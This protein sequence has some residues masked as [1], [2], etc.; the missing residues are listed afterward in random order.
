[1]ET[2]GESAIAR[3]IGTV[4][5][6]LRQFRSGFPDL[7]VIHPNGEFEF[8]EVKAPGDQIQRNQRIW[9]EELAST[10]LPARVMRFV[11]SH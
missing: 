2:L 7:T 5:S 1:M 10:K 6:D 4:K 3:L 11:V 9:L 8:V